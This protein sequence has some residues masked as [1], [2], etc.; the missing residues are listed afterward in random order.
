MDFGI[1]LVLTFIRT[2][3][4]IV[5]Y[6]HLDWVLIDEILEI[7]YVYI[8]KLKIYNIGIDVLIWT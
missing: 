6:D 7:V 5:W 4:M 3:G 1:D 2:F 8:H